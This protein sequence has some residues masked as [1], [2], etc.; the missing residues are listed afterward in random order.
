MRAKGR[1]DTLD[2]LIS[3]LSASRPRK[4]ESGSFEISRTSKE[5]MSRVKYVLTTGIRPFD[6]LTGGIPFGRLSEFY[7]LDASGKTAFVMRSAVRAQTRHIYELGPNK[8]RTQIGDDIDV[9]VL[10]IDNEQSLADDD[11]LTIDGVEIDAALAR[12]D[13]ID[14]MFKLV[15]MTI[16]HL[17][18]VQKETKRI[19]LLLIIVDTIA[20]T[21]SK[22]EMAAEW[23]KDDYNR[24]P[25][26]LREGF[27]NLIRKI[28]RFNV[29]M[30][31]TNQ[32]SDSF[33]PKQKGAR[34]VNTNVPDD[35]DFSTF[36]GRSLKFYARLRVFF[37]SLRQKYTL[38]KGAKFTAGFLAGFLTVKNS[39][40]KPRREGR[41]VLLYDN[42]LSDTYSILETLCF[43]KFIETN[44]QGQFVVRYGDNGIK[45]KTYSG[46]ETTLEEDDEF[47]EEQPKPRRNSKKKVVDEEEEEEEKPKKKVVYRFDSRG[48]WPGYYALHKED[49]EA[50]YAKA[51][52][53]CFETEGS[54][55]DALQGIVDDDIE[56]DADESDE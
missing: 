50:L 29:A 28:N 36:G 41:F 40:T 12:C 46:S 56:V 26:Q 23:G 51:I 14:Q 16:D 20:G 6:D 13:T 5:I 44:D 47:E 10:Y 33:K 22:E 25:K 2:S 35:A 53:Y 9:T 19:Q 1:K 4:G 42:G 34:P 38:V 3:K 15:D 21:S 49:L 24:Q 8:E 54:T 18:A 30:V 17:R 7:G 32:V 52:E 55:P 45:P 11:K 43:V 39:Q 37:Y 48:E 31:C 27:R